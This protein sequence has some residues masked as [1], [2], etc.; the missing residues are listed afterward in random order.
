[1]SKPNWALVVDDHPLSAMGV[2]QYLASHEDLRPVYIAHGAQEAMRLIEVWGP[3]KL[4]VVDYWL[5]DG[6]SVGLISHLR[7]HCNKAVVLVVSADA[8]PDVRAKARALGAHGFSDK[9]APA[10]EFGRALAAVLRGMTWFYPAP[11]S[12]QRRVPV[13]GRHVTTRELGLTPRQGEI[14]ECVV[15]GWP[16]KRIAAF[17]SVSE[18]TIKEHMTAILHKLEVS[19]RVEVITKLRGRTLVLD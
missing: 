15:Q 13:W 7:C 18:S 4:A 19:N 12:A 3:P 2:A 6:S 9:Q 1:M 10:E 11:H 16:N 14:L 5:T 17:L 8:S